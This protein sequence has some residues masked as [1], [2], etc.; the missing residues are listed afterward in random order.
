LNGGGSRCDEKLLLLDRLEREKLLF[1]PG[2]MSEIVWDLLFPNSHVCNPFL[3]DELCDDKESTHRK[4]DTAMEAERLG[5]VEGRAGSRSR[6]V[7]D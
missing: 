7:V 2:D 3:L 5:A 4:S 1:I 6:R